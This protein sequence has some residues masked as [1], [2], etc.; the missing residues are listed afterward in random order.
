VTVRSL[1]GRQTVSMVATHLAPKNR[2]TANIMGPSIRRLGALV[3]GLSAYG[4]VF[5]GGDFNRHYTSRDFPRSGLTAAGLTPSYDLA[6]FYLPTGDHHGATIDYVMLRPAPLFRVLSQTTTEM[7]SDHDLLSVVLS[8]PATTTGERP[9]S[10]PPGTSVNDPSSTSPNARRALVR[11][12]RTAINNATEGAQVRLSTAQLGDRGVTVALRRAYK[13]GV[14]VKVI[15]GSATP[16]RFET[17]LVSL[18][19]SRKKA[20]SWIRFNPAQATRRLAT[21]TLLADRTGA[22]T[23]LVLTA[24]R[25]MDSSLVS[26]PSRTT[27]D[28]SSH[29][30][31][32]SKVKVFGALVRGSHR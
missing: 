25:A 20:A 28:T 10:F 23:Y 11:T 16:T 1:D 30:G 17:S 19:G 2:I 5:V 7:Y 32:Q 4:P 13:R 18:I 29:S 8:L 26:E 31:F 24:N 27:V 12:I 9:I 6:G 14:D 15:S 22:T 3:S 21:S